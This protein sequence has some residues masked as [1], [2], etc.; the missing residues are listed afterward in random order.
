VIRGEWRGE[1]ALW[2]GEREGGREGGRE[3]ETEDTRIYKQVRR[4]EGNRREGGREGGRNRRQ[5]FMN[6]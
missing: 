5:G 4:E 6:R 3:G 2:E 1:S